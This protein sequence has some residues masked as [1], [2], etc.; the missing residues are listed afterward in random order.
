MNQCFRV[1]SLPPY[2]LG[3]VSE[4]VIKARIAGRDVIDL[5]QVNPD[6]LVP[7]RAVDKLVESVLRQQNHRY[8]SSQ[9]IARLRKAVSRLYGQRFGVELSP[10]KEICAVMGTKEGFAHL[11][12]AVLFAGDHVLMPSPSYPIHTAAIAIAGASLVSFPLNA[13]LYSG[14]GEP[15]QAQ[16]LTGSS[17]SFF[18]SLTESIAAAWPKPR[19]LILSFPHNPT[20]TVVSHDFFERIIECA[21]EHNLLVV[22]DFAYADIT[23]DGYVAPSIL[24]VPGASDCAVEFYSLSKAYG[25]AGWR[26]SFCVGNERVIAAVKK[27][28]S[29]LD[30]GIFQAVQI[31]AATLIEN[32]IS[33]NQAEVSHASVCAENADLYK[34]RRD[35]LV[36]GLRSIG[37][38]VGLPQATVFVWAKIP[39]MYGSVDSLA[40]SH[41][42][43]ENA[44]VAVCPGIGF[45]A[46]T[47][48][49]VRFALMESESRLRLAINRISE[50]PAI[51]ESVL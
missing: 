12:G 16:M 13:E 49:Y 36:K 18:Q 37:W 14:Y 46:S 35:V 9:G 47:D 43:L 15:G 29:Y 10:D 48:S 34:N 51:V 3:S 28:K 7:S 22:H 4:A 31:A 11:L 5:G 1:D 44:D 6:I 42:L 23:F 40:F 32:E 26:V 38:D 41:H 17:E 33:E 27:I 8:S 45:S 30:F 25:V 50:C 21:K 39:S 24:H 19:M 20:A 2:P